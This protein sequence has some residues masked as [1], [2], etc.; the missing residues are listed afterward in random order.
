MTILVVGAT[1]RLGGEIARRLLAAG[2]EPVRILVRP[3]ARYDE[4]A[5]L[6]ALPVTGDLKDRGSLDAAVR[7]VATIVTTAN[8]AQRGGADSAEAV[9]QQGNRNLIDAARA[10]GVGHFVFISALGADEQSAVGLMRGKGMTERALRES[11]MGYT[12]LA[13]N[14]FMDVWVPLVV[15]GPTLAGGQVTIVG[16]G[17]RR[18]AFVAMADV[19]VIAAATVGNAAARDAYIPIGGPDAVSWRD[20]IATFERVSGRQIAVHSVAPGAPLP[21]YPE[22]IGGLLT[23]MDTYDSPLDMTETARTFGVRLTSLEE[24]TRRAF[25]GTGA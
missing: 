6:G 18:H 12:I 21:G 15:G 24:Y 13:P 7:D 23:A 10:G 20:V 5:A 8:S 25:G 9:D 2:R 22:V 1:G 3:G 19:A 16:E 11:G 17:R 14:V 4:L